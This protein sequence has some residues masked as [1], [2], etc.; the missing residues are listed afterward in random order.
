MIRSLRITGLA[1]TLVATSLFASSAM[2]GARDELN[3][4]TKG[5]KGLDG[6]F[7]Q[8]VFDT[9]GKLKETASGQLALSAPRLFRWEYVKPYPQL[10]VADGSK[11]WIYDEDLE[12]VTVRP[13]GVEEQSNPLAA[14]INPGKL[15]TMFVVQDAGKAAGLEWLTLSPRNEE[16]ASFRSARLGFDG[17]RL[18]RM[19]VV[20]A[21][22]Q[23][24]EIGFSNWKRNPKFAGGTFKYSPPAGVDVI[25]N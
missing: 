23:R 10:I 13:Q 24:T 15:D 18:A 14:L 22:G 16:E 12:Q 3:A 8:Q 4:F 20:D 7:T 17:A 21:L 19:E 11:V 5:L 9:N 6:Q 2:A 1:G 25:G